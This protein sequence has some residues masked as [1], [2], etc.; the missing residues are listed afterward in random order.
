LIHLWPQQ[1]DFEIYQQ[2]LLYTNFNNANQTLFLEY[3]FLPLVANLPA[4]FVKYFVYE[5]AAY[6]ALA[7]AQMP[8]YYSELE[9]KKGVELAIA[10]CADAQNRPQTPLQSQPVLSRRFVTTFA[11]G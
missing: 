6:L 9:R 8:D 2:N 10:Q 7:N 5:I 3:Q 1:W 4:Y 11:S